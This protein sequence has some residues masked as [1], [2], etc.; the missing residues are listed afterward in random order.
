MQGFGGNG[1]QTEGPGGRGRSADWLVGGGELGELIRTTDWSGT[2]L[3]PRVSWPQPLRTVLN[4][5]VASQFPMALL[6]GSELLL[7][8]NDAYRVIAADKHPAALGRSTREVWPEVWHINEPIFAAVMDRGETLYFEDR[9]FRINRT[10]HY[11]DASFTLCYSPVHIEDGS[12]GGALVVLEDT[13]K[14]LL[15]ER[16]L[17]QTTADLEQAQSV[18]GIGSWKFVRET[19]SVTWSKELFRIFDTKESEFRASHASFLERVHPDDRDRVDATNRHASETRTPFALEY[20]I[21]TRSGTVRWIRE[22]GSAL[23]KPDGTVIGLM[24]TAQDVTEQK[25]AA[26]SLRQSEAKQAFLLKLSD[27]MQRI[28]A[29]DAKMR[30]ACA[31]LGEHL[32]ADRVHYGEHDEEQGVIIV[33]P[34]YFRDGHESLS[35]RYPQSFFD[36]MPPFLRT[37]RAAAI[38]DTE[39][40]PELGESAR[41]AF[42][43]LQV[44]ALIAAPLVSG[45]RLAWS[46]TVVSD[47]PREWTQQEVTLVEEVGNRTW[48][49][50]ERARASTALREANLRLAEAAHRKTAFLGLLSHELRNPLAPIANTLYILDHTMPGGEQAKRAKTVIGRQLAQLTTL[51]NELLEVTRLTHGKVALH[52]DRLDLNAVVSRAVE[53]NRPLFDRV[54]VS[55][56]LIPAPGEVV[57]RADRN[58]VA[59]IVGKLLQNASKFTP[60][61]GSTQVFLETVAGYAVLRVKDTGIGMDALT[62]VRAFELFQST[63][64]TVDRGEDGLGIGLALVKGLVEL[65][66][67]TV[68]A[69]SDGSGKGSEFVVRLPLD[70]GVETKP[71]PAT[72][73]PR[74]A[75]KRIL[76]IE[77][78][79]DAAG[80]LREALQLHGYEVEVA[81][82]G[83]EGIAKAHEF[84]PDVLL[85][86]IGLPGVSGYEV[87]RVFRGDERL[88]TAY[89]VALSGYARPPDLQRAAEAGF[90]MHLAK[91]ASIEKIEA[92][93]RAVPVR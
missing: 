79:V 51:V 35:G 56:E 24:G 58:R 45:G 78:N 88:K 31:L 76:L 21:I 54:G 64:E 61:G 22:V 48:A 2:S 16:D 46:L 37:G 13:T 7:L 82:D 30:A 60:A 42:R 9:P 63:G 89:L 53:D 32:G 86:D 84:H 29:T 55:L 18:A 74:E 87:A 25:L 52:T 11:E 34:D 91:P 17:R 68:G 85:C 12:V 93:L 6:W 14:R 41:A 44:R 40:S 1:L 75:A 62:T 73:S 8:Y 43:R 59:Q 77:D 27:R 50:F 38:P 49:A 10:G 66:G 20:R 26:D 67:G 15:L 69:H 33:H 92:V 5:V 4:L 39:T 81:Y 71:A 23:R 36:E 47:T 65:H 83:A 19:R 72:A 28:E 3:G 57:V 90:E 80:S 70:S